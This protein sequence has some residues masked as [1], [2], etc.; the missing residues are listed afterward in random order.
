[1]LKVL[2]IEDDP[3]KR[4][5]VVEV[6]HSIPELVEE[7]VHT[8]STL[9]HAR[10]ILSKQF[11]D[12]LVL[13]I[14]LPSFD[15]QQP[16][17]DAGTQFL[18]ELRLS[19]TLIKPAHVIGLTA[20]DS[21]LLQSDPVFGDEVWR[22][23]KYDPTSEAW[24][25]QLKSKVAYLLRCKQEMQ[26][27]ERAAYE[28]DLA[29]VTA[30]W[31]PELNA[32]KQLPIEWE[33]RVIANDATE[34][35][36]GTANRSGRR[37]NVV[38]ASCSQMG[39]APATVLTMKMIGHFRPRYLAICGIAAGVKE[40]GLNLGDIVVAEQSWDYESGKRRI[41]EDGQPMLLPDPHHIP[42]SA[43]LRDWFANCIGQD[44]YVREIQESWAGSKAASILQAAMGP[45]GSGAAVIEDKNVVADV[46]GH[47][48]K[49]LAIEMETYGVFFAA[50]NC[51]KPRPAALA[52]KSIVDFA[53]DN[54]NDS[55]QEY[56][57][58]T[59]AQYLWRFAL[60][61]LGHP[62]PDNQLLERQRQ[63][64]HTDSERHTDSVAASFSNSPK[65]S[66]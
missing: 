28:Y 48:R 27:G 35:I 55:A 36:V 59:S 58:F 15:G 19:N 39:I 43:D 32:V 51:C 61:H 50:Q 47:A 53:D 10:D 64:T 30:L 38:A 4:D 66:A 8:A 60:D 16:T 25:N 63:H 18:R 57:A 56:A 52:I 17:S 62:T 12:L 42:I 24:R 40:S 1:M 13:D 2:V 5:H 6:V 20:F 29:I 37:L 49:L 9:V 3:A 33:R 46:K 45:V 65:N 26:T 31:K 21:A 23:I 44:K 41:D 7:S 14:L 34:Y 22:V 54:K 11:F